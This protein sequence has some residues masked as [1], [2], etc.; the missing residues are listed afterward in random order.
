[1]LPT[2]VGV[3][4]GTWITSCFDFLPQLSNLTSGPT[5]LCLESG[6]W[7]DIGGWEVLALISHFHAKSVSGLGSNQVSDLG[8]GAFLLLEIFYWQYPRCRQRPGGKTEWEIFFT[9]T[10]SGPIWELPLCSW[11]L[12]DFTP[13]VWILPENYNS[14]VAQMVKSLPAMLG[15]LGSIPGLGRSLG[16]MNGNPLQY[17]CLKN[18]MD[19]RASK[20]QSME[21]QRVGHEWMTN[22]EN[23]KREAGQDLQHQNEKRGFT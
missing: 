4:S 10:S 18:S 21:L 2:S 12:R 13:L 8:M 17:S 23:G 22:A 9:S 20:L 16:E 19:R 5:A 6:E 14:P 11:Q 1:M 15:D 7:G 3:G